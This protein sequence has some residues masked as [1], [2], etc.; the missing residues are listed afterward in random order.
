MNRKKEIIHV[1]DDGWNLPKEVVEEI[2]FRVTV[3]KAEAYR[4][5]CRA[6]DLHKGKWLTLEVAQKYEAKSWIWRVISGE[7]YI[8]KV[9]EIEEELQDEYGVTELE[10]INILRGFH[11]ADY[12]NKYD[13][14]R[15]K[16]P[17]YVD[18]QKIVAMV[19]EEYQVRAM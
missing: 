10:A 5:V 18:E 3:A 4:E 13:R 19:T 6:H 16:I 1:I 11:H 15:R 7:Q 14:I 12:V 17:N 9:R 8:G 2:E